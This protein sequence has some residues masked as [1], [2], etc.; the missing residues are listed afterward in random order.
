MASMEEFQKAQDDW[1]EKLLSQDQLCDAEAVLGASAKKVPFIGALLANVSE[2]LRAALFGEFKE[3]SDKRITMPDVTPEAFRIIMRAAVHLN[4]QLSASNVVETLKA[5]KLYM[6]ESLVKL[7][8]DYI[9]LIKAEEILVVMTSAI[10][11]DYALPQ[12]LQ[13]GLWARIILDP[14]K[15][16][17][18][19]SFVGAHG[20]IIDRVVKL[21]E[22]EV[23][24]D[25]LWSALLKWSAN[26]VLQPQL[27]G[28]FSDLAPELS[29]SKRSKELH[30]QTK[31]SL[32]P[33]Q[34]AQ[35][36]AI[37]QSLSHQLRL[38]TMSKHYFVD[39][40]K[41]YI[42]RED[43]E[44]ILTFYLLGRQPPPP[45]LTS[46]RS[47]LRPVEQLHP[48]YFKSCRASGDAENLSLGRGTWK[49]ISAESSLEVQSP[50][51]IRVT[52][53]R[54]TFAAQG[55]VWVPTVVSGAIEYQQ[56][57]ET[58]GR[59]RTVILDNAPVLSTAYQ[60][61]I[62]VT[63]PSGKAWGSFAELVNVEL[64]GRKSPKEYALEVVQ[65]RSSEFGIVEQS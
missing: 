19:E 16:L 25:D 61:K 35:Q 64:F 45:L 4:P 5:A 37:L 39:K 7:C 53:I 62:K 52:K 58:A 12:K 36:V 15:I 60:P 46:K 63:N 24:E 31:G 49:P 51:D 32:G 59:M 50:K 14:A 30:E 38:G 56:K 42:S 29:D 28:P 44:M 65:R 18:A 55:E 48:A 47:G 54:L 26:A 41:P 21:D 2:P 6:I 1:S 9:E 20:S 3:G 22:L 40:V 33:N 8:T 34:L 17:K 27:L 43:T 57:L 23:K 10:F 11:L 13:E